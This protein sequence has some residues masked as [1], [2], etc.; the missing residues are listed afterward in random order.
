MCSQKIGVK[1]AYVRFLLYKYSFTAINWFYIRF[2]IFFKIVNGLY[3][4]IFY[5]HY[6]TLKTLYCSLHVFELIY[7]CTAFSLLYVDCECYCIL[8]KIWMY[9]RRKYYWCPQM[10]Y[11]IRCKLLIFPII[12]YQYWTFLL[13]KVIA[14]AIPH[15]GNLI[16][17]LFGIFDAPIL[18][19]MTVVWCIKRYQLIFLSLPK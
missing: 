7:F 12:R 8:L 19:S 5:T 13:T 15:Y 17:K 3:Y 18:F 1:C 6:Y 9:C 16:P 11:W 2:M 14:I 4:S 10:R